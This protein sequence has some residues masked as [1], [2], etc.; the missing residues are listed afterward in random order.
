M[1]VEPHVLVQPDRPKDQWESFPNSFPAALVTDVRK[2]VFHP[3]SAESAV[4]PEPVG[5]GDPARTAFICE[6]MPML[7]CEF[8]HVA[9]VTESLLF[10]HY[11]ARLI[12]NALS[13]V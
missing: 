12:H 13:S 11:L 7:R 2:P 6:T 3:P 9:S 1:L 4:N 8:S 10:L 5:K